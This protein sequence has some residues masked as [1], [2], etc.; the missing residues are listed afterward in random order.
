MSTSDNAAS[1]S[2]DLAGL[3][4]IFVRLADKARRQGLLSLEED[5]EHLPSD[6]F[7]DALAE[8]IDGTPPEEITELMGYRI[9]EVRERREAELRREVAYL[10]MLQTG[11][12]AVQR[13][14]APRLVRDL[15][16]A[17]LPPAARTRLPRAE[18]YVPP[19][20]AASAPAPGWSEED[21]RALTLDSVLKLSR[22]DMSRLTRE[23]DS[24]DLALA[25][26]GASQEVQQRFFRAV[27]SRSAAALREDI[28]IMGPQRV[29]AIQEAQ[30]KIV[31][32]MRHLAQTKRIGAAETAASAP[33]T[34]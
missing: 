21:L 29:T 17:Q 25:L 9:R 18:A 3:V 24:R 10:R 5:M 20:G 8:V 14:H 31:Q 1:E 19:G 7:R 6:A 32:I 11:V 34:A 27:S 28:E 23:L 30:Q 2:P 12:L 26:R 15:L 16:E 33:P 4:P 22:R 13:G